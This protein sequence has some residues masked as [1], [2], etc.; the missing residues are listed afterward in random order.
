[1]NKF[2]RNSK[3]RH[4]NSKTEKAFLQ[5]TFRWLVGI[6]ILIVGIC[7]HAVAAP[8]IEYLYPAG[9]QQNRT[10][11]IT[12]GGRSLEGASEVWVSGSG[13]TGK[14]L[15]VNMPTEAQIREAR[16]R[17]EV[18]AQT[19]RVRLTIAPDAEPG[20]RD[21]RVMATAGLSNRF[22]FEIGKLPEVSE[23][24]PNGHLADA[25]QLP[26]LPVVVNGQVTNADRDFFRFSARAGQQIL[27][28]VKARAIKS[29][30]ADAVPGWFQ[31]RIVLYNSEGDR[32]AEADD[33]RF[34]PDPVMFFKAPGDGDYIVEIW[35]AV[36]RGRDDLVYRMK[37]GELPYVTDIFPLGA[38]QGVKHHRFTA[39]GINLPGETADWICDVSDRQ[40][41]VSEIS[42]T[43]ENGEKTNA[44]PIE[45]SELPEVAE[46]EPNNAQRQAQRVTTPVIIN[47]RI[48]KPGDIDVFT[49]SAKTGDKLVIDVMARRLGSPLD[50][51]IVLGP[52]KLLG[53]TLTADDVKDERFGLITHHA[54]PRLAHTFTQ[55]GDYFVHLS[56]TQGKGGVEYAYRLSIA[57]QQ[58]DF[59]LRVTPDNLSVPAGGN[60]VVQLKSIR[61]DDYNDP[62]R[63]ST[64][65]LPPGFELAG[66]EVKAGKNQ[67]ILT[68]S[69]PL[70]AKPGVY[71][72]L[73]RAEAEIDGKT[74]THKANVAEELMQAFFYYHTVPVEQGYLVVTPASPFRVE[75]MRPADAGPLE[76]TLGKECE[77]PVRII[78]DPNYRPPVAAP[79]PPKAKAG[80][81]T[82]GKATAKKKTTSKNKSAAAGKNAGKKN[83]KKPVKK[84]Q[85]QS[86][87][88]VPIRVMASRGGKGMIVEVAVIEAGATEGVVKVRCTNE[89]MVGEE[90]VFIIEATQRFRGQKTSSLAPALP[91]KVLPAEDG[92]PVNLVR[93]PS[94]KKNQPKK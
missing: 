60:V 17:D 80:A 70:D 8:Y 58:P 16:K 26:A 94:E 36:S 22:R 29:Y 4:P 14:V 48:D 67:T 40:P 32:L 66:A 23:K 72:P 63:L 78:R 18:A 12:L 41:G 20:I 3:F 9:A 64:E 7:G 6:W 52:Q 89:K 91:F 46:Y 35:D 33:F 84:Q 86:A 37:I 2:Q 73:F 93:D 61:I 38:P 69:A 28:E 51:R 39:R 50:A 1:M 53:K 62:I 19:A 13:V 24:E 47:G 81:G 59:E 83:A 68:L 88:K 76:L 49:F 82:K 25:Q 34:D 71:K 90:G 30:L 75:V 85:P 79:Q 11:E 74:V 57:P 10:M 87:A 27:I 21:L 77:I 65:G 5:P 44:R 45:I 43:L 31:P 55:D 92:E 15:E 42:F 54:D 56:D